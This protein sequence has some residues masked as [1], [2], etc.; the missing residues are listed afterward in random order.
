MEGKLQ[1]A[2][3]TELQV[4]LQTKGAQCRVSTI[5]CHHSCD[6]LDLPEFIAVAQ[7]EVHVL[8][9]CLERPDE[10]PAVLQ[11]TAHPVVDVLKHLTALPDR[12]EI[13][14]HTQTLHYIIV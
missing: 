1:W 6:L 14:T 9:E 11:Y 3:V 12:L 5:L 8:V 7:D 10:Y 13:N 4:L 2:V